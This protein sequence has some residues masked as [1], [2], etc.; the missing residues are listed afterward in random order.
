MTLGAMGL[1]GGGAWNSSVTRRGL[2]VVAVVLLIAGV[3]V[4]LARWTTPPGWLVQPQKVSA[5]VVGWVSTN[6]DLLTIV[7]AVAL[8]G[9]V[10]LVL[11][12]LERRQR[13]RGAE[14][15]PRDRDRAVM[16]RRVRN[17]WI[18]GVLEQSLAEEARIRL[19][20]TRRPEVIAPP[21][22]IIRRP[23]GR[24]EPLPAG[25]SISAVFD[26]ID[27]GLLVLGAPG[28]GKTTG[29]LELARDLLRDAEADPGQPIPVV[30]N[31]SSWAAKRLPLAEWLIEELRTSYEV[32]RQIASRWVAAGDILP[33]LDGLDEVAAA[34]RAGCVE[35]INTYHRQ[36]GLVR[37][38][39]C[40]R[41]EEY[42]AVA[43]LVQVEEA[44]EFQPPTHEQISDYFAAAGGALADVQ[45]ALKADETL[46]E[47]LQSPL[48][49]NIVAL[50]YQDRLA[51]ALRATGT[52]EERLLLL[53]TAYTERMF[54]HRPG[55]YSPARM[56]HWLA[57]LARSMHERAQTEFQ[58]DRMQPDWLPS[59]TQQRLATVSTAMSVGL[60]VGL[61][62]SLAFGLLYGLLYGL[63]DGLTMTVFAGLFV[64]LRVTQPVEGIAGSWLRTR[65]AV[66]GSLITGLLAGLSFGLFFGMGFGLAY[67]V[68]Y[69]IFYALFY[70]LFAG[71]TNTE[72]VE[73]IRWSWPRLHSKLVVGMVAGLVL[74]LVAGLPFWL[75]SGLAVGLAV[76]LAHGL[77]FG[78]VNVL[79]YGLVPGLVDERLTPNEG[80]YRSARHALALGLPSGLI[81][82]LVSGLVFGLINGLRTGLVYGLAYGLFSGLIVGLFFGGVACLQHL[83]LRGLLTVHGYAPLRYLRFLDEATERL[84]LRRAGSGYIFVHRLLLDYFAGLDTTRSPDEVKR[85]LAW[86]LLALV[87]S[88]KQS[89]QPTGCRPA[90]AV[91]HPSLPQKHG[92]RFPAYPANVHQ[93]MIDVPKD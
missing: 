65:N 36:H 7:R 12:P 23:G 51:D 50:T 63:V 89:R 39:V 29:L 59:T 47:F 45:A 68:F 67:A 14:E 69:A 18:K 83:V 4:A 10:K 42:R 8:A 15:Q 38:A 16:L 62:D 55:R 53:L 87:S 90:R 76:G 66:R 80:I 56:L 79:F 44:V 60:L 92:R 61:V 86:W 5:E 20:L 34:R 75:F 72:P 30:F 2:Q 78:L 73:E 21:A 74:G 81:V 93:G 91:A 13:H 43:R 85:P 1:T 11:L 40:C 49:L 32:P 58:L 26:E 70:A 37:F 41:T 19:G 28:S 9:I 46:W 35:A 57:W 88:P 33:L 82:W 84:F 24:P 48:V 77:V 71:L 25:T 52:L 27:G 3:V 54:E 17:R 64:G 31:L 22:A 6:L